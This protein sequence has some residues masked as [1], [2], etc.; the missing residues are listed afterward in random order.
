MTKF[1]RRVG[2]YNPRGENRQDVRP[3]RVEVPAE[4]AHARDRLRAPGRCP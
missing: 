2:S 3:G 4:Q 1:P